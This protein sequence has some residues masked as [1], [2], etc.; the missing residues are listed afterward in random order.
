MNA[1]LPNFDDDPI[2]FLACPE[3]TATALQKAMIIYCGARNDTPIVLVNIA[4]DQTKTQLKVI[5]NSYQ[6]SDFS[7]AVIRANWLKVSDP[8]ANSVIAPD[9]TIPNVGHVMGAEIYTIGTLGIHWVSA[10]NRTILKGVSGVVGDQF[11]NDDDRTEL[12]ENGINL[13]QDRTGIGIK[14]ANSFT[15]ST[16]VA[17]L[18]ENILLMRNYIKVSAEDSL[19][20]DENTPNT[21]NRIQAGKMA[22]LT[23][24]YNL[25][26]RGSTGEV[27]EGETFGQQEGTVAEDH[28]QVKS[29]VTVNPQTSIN[30][31]ERTY[32]VYFTAP[33]P[34][35]SIE[36]GVGV[37]IRS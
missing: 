22:I 7:P 32:T 14:I 37:L 4:E 9:R 1:F 30:L 12:A 26:F 23:W 10:S 3:T 35:A 19:S 20:G 24:L 21:Y 16:D 15:V 34:S 11:L 18:H 2:R 8:F 36:I 33:P 6:V 31:G 17:Y 25:W 5:G 27:P 29:D 13:I 28:F